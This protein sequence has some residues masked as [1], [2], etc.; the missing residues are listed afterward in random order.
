MTGSHWHWLGLARARPLP[1]NN[2]VQR[3]DSI[4]VFST[5]IDSHW[6]WLGAGKAEIQQIRS[7]GKLE[8]MESPE[9]R[10]DGVDETQFQ[11]SFKLRL[12]PN[13]DK[14]RY[15]GAIGLYWG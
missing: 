7:D 6:H 14:E 8:R 12:F 1:M 5:H 3:D 11:Y 9:L 15:K 2:R 10:W 13:S 4:L